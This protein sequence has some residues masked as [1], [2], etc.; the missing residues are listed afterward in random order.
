MHCHLDG[1]VA[2]RASPMSKA[3]LQSTTRE[4]S[5][6]RMQTRHAKWFRIAML[7]LHCATHDPRSASNLPH[8]ARDHSQGISGA[9]FTTILDNR[10]DML[11][12]RT[13]FSN[14]LQSRKVFGLHVAPY[15]N[16]RDAGLANQVEEL[17]GECN[18]ESALADLRD[19]RQTGGHAM[20]RQSSPFWAKVCAPAFKRIAPKSLNICC[21]TS[22]NLAQGAPTRTSARLRNSNSDAKNL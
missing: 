22:L 5:E 20:P 6:A 19:R 11:C 1:R 12:G 10:L 15:R 9:D 13:S 18:A 16:A 4:I 14:T 8:W 7:G 17:R 21:V 3:S 2:T